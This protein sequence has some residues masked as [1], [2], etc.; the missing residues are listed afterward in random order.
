ME[1]NNY[2]TCCY[3]SSYTD[4]DGSRQE[5]VCNEP[6]LSYI[7][8]EE[9]GPNG[10]EFVS[11]PFCDQHLVRAAMDFHATTNAPLHPWVIIHKVSDHAVD[12]NGETEASYAD[13]D[14][15]S[16]L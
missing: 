11:Y 12:T 14:F 5:F 6:R 16:M 4:Y 9:M 3:S 15:R 13:Q 8:V 1:P 10:W 2:G 7:I